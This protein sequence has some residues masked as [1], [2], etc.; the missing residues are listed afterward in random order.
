VTLFDY[1]VRVMRGQS[2]VPVTVRAETWQEAREAL[3]SGLP[4]R[5]KREG[6]DT[7]IDRIDQVVADA[8]KAEVLEARVH[9]LE[10]SLAESNSQVEVEREAAAGMAATINAQQRNLARMQT[11]TDAFGRALVKIVR[12]DDSAGALDEAKGWARD[13]FAE[14]DVTIP[15]VTEPAK[16]IIPTD[17]EES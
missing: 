4:E 2:G 15:G 9:E 5:W 6:V 7:R 17:S 12:M 1:H 10:Q 13:A 14:V 3:V 8:A 11:E 16:I